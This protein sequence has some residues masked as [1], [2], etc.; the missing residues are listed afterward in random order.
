LSWRVFDSE[1]LFCVCLHPCRLMAEWREIRKWEASHHTDHDASI[2][3]GRDGFEAFPVSEGDL[4]L[5]R[6]RFLVGGHGLPDY[7]NDSVC[8]FKGACFEADLKFDAEYPFQ[9]PALKF[10]EPIPYHPNVYRDDRRHGDICISILHKSGVDA[11]NEGESSDVRWKSEYSIRAICVHV[12]DLIG[13]P[14][15]N[16]GTW[17][18][19]FLSQPLSR[20]HFRVVGT[21]ASAAVNSV[22]RQTPDVFAV[23]TEECAKQSRAK[24]PKDVFERALRD[25]TDYDALHAEYYRKLVDDR[26]KE[27]EERRRLEELSAVCREPPVFDDDTPSSGSG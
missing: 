8:K 15:M 16:G 2:V 13:H 25:K 24:A 7:A 26:A 27:A 11:F 3:L 5:W 19:V 14:N 23:K 18:P 22:L 17:P 20:S 21:P 12:L 9:P 1:S 6:L 4:S 10:I